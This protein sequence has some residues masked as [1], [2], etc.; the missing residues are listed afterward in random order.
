MN[1]WFLVVLVTIVM[2]KYNII[3]NY[4]EL[5]FAQLPLLNIWWRLLQSSAPQ[6]NEKA[7]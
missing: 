4:D 5:L 1:V 2:V 3:Y 7:N 6:E